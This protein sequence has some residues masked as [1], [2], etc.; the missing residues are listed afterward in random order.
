MGN[1]ATKAL[2]TVGKRSPQKGVHENIHRLK[3]E[4]RESLTRTISRREALPAVAVPDRADMRRTEKFPSDGAALRSLM[5][6][7]CGFQT[8]GL[9]G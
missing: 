3:K 9:P 5:N 7:E 4:A 1:W 6:R 2:I 8:S